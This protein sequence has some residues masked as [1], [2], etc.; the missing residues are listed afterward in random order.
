MTQLARPAFV[1]RKYPPIASNFHAADHPVLRLIHDK[2]TRS[3][4]FGLSPLDGSAAVTRL[5]LIH[6]DAMNAEEQGYWLIADDFWERIYTSS[7]L[8]YNLE[9]VWSTIGGNTER[10]AFYAE[11]LADTHLAYHN[12]YNDFL[13]SKTRAEY[14]KK[15]AV[16]Y[17]QLL[18]MSQSDIDALRNR[19]LDQQIVNAWKSG[20]WVGVIANCNLILKTEP[21]SIRYINLA[22]AAAMRIIPQNEKQTTPLNTASLASGI[23]AIERARRLEPRRYFYYEQL[24]TLSHLLAIAQF[25]SLQIAEALENE[26]RALTFRPNFPVAQQSLL[27]MRAERA[28]LEN[29]LRAVTTN[30]PRGRSLSMQGMQLQSQL[31]ASA[32]VENRYQTSTAAA[33]IAKQRRIALGA[34]IWESAQLPAP[35]ADAD[36]VYMTVADELDA[37]VRAN[38]P[39][40]EVPLKWA[41][42]IAKHPALHPL[43]ADKLMIYIQTWVTNPTPPIPVS[44]VLPEINTTN[45]AQRIAPTGKMQNGGQ[46]GQK[47]IGYWWY[48][49]ASGA[50]RALLI[51]AL[52]VLFVGLGAQTYGRIQQSQRDQ[53][54]QTVVNARQTAYQQLIA[55]SNAGDYAAGLD[56]A[57]AFFASPPINGTDNRMSQVQ[58]LYRELLVAWIARTAPAQAEIDARVNRFNALQGR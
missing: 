34:T 44:V 50:L 19:A 48:S 15:Q 47:P 57:E 17:F 23:E 9:S 6:Q 29:Q 51:A 18:K 14:H 42:V 28:K 40:L 36:Q 12:G 25:N 32:G 43:S 53:Q 56:A 38:T 41:A 5:L 27:N 4:R 52:L 46:R 54:M 24:A 45:T 35:L 58:T 7:Q 37:L 31:F 26:N 10:D 3:Q 1:P 39:L 22:A 13:M 20:D 33:E 21:G 55:A 30:L 11:V 2:L 8:L 49:P 16:R